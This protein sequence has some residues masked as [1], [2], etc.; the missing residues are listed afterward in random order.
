MRRGSDSFH[1][2]PDE[3]R[4]SLAESIFIVYPRLKQLL[5]D[6]DHCRTHSKI[7]AE[8][9]CMFIGG[10]AGAG[11]T[12]TQLYYLKQFQRKRFGD[13][14][15]IPALRARVPNRA[16]DKTLVTALLKS[17][18]DPAAEM[19]S[20]YRQTVRLINRMN[21]AGVEICHIDEFQ[22][23]VDKD[24]AKVLKNVSD[25][26][27]NLIDESA[28]P[29]IIW[30]MPYADQILYEVGNEQLRRRFSIRKSL[31]P[32]GWASKTEK[33]E[34][35]A[36]LKKVDE[37]LPFDSCSGLASITMAFRFYCATNGRIGYVMKI[38]RRASEIAIRSK[39][40]ILN[41]EVLAQAYHDRLMADYPNRNNPFATDLKDLRIIS[42]E[43]DVPNFIHSRSKITD[44]R[45]T[46]SNVLRT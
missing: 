24:S 28:R 45:E 4:I 22:H 1:D 11:K 33:D 5:D 35:R 40:P 20:A 3:E 39:M 6:I 15:N 38:I 9:E 23:F 8:P 26:L 30:G 13:G 36:F 41:L 44:K 7:S 29:F 2:M 12:T 25:W 37:K 21:D 43:E 19:G 14:W 16:T 17:I 31:D 27:K 34:Y 46:A 10:L 42:F 32:F 18:G